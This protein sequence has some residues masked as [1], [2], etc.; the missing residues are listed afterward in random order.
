MFILKN[1]YA[2]ILFAFFIFSFVGVMSK[3]AALSEAFSIR[4]FIFVGLQIFILGVY[5]ILWQQIL[6]KFTLVSAMSF[7]GV[8]VI[9]SLIWATVIFRENITIFNIIGSLVIVAGIYIVS[10]EE[11]AAEKK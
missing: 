4:F 3:L 9:F 7:R 6:K 10:S 2:Q 11:S 5:A 1:K 8:V